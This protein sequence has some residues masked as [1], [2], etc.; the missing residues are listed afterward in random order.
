MGTRSKYD[1]KIRPKTVHLAGME[2]AKLE[3]RKNEQEQE[4]M[5]VPRYRLFD[6][7]YCGEVCQSLDA[8]EAAKNAHS[9]S[10]SRSTNI[11]RQNI[12]IQTDSS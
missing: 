11:R 3:T 5:T 7:F 4:S 2:K 8:V 10:T 6:F 12:I 1:F 9:W